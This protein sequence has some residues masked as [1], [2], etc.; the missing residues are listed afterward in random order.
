ML[1]EY[2]ELEKKLVLVGQGNK[3]EIWSEALWQGQMN[4]WLAD[5]GGDLLANGD[6]FTGL[7]V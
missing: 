4:A 6:D 1:R 2:G 3:I 5:A 7:S